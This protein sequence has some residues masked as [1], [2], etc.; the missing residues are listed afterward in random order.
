MLSY[1]D[2][3]KR[4]IEQRNRFAA[5]TSFKQII[6]STDE[7]QIIAFFIFFSGLG[8][9]MTKPVESWIKR[10]GQACVAKGFTQVGNLL[11]KHSVEEAS[12]HLMLIKD[13][14][15]LT[16]LWNQKCKL[17]VNKDAIL[18]DTDTQ[19]VNDYK[20]VHEDTIK[21]APWGQVAIEYEIENLS[22]VYGTRLVEKYQKTVNKTSSKGITFLKDHVK[23][24]VGHTEFNRNLI[25]TV[26]KE[27]PNSLETLVKSGTQALEAY[28]QFSNDC[29]E[30]A[31]RLLER[32]KS[33]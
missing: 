14:D 21:N 33:L 10:A 2:Y 32:E 13:L 12:H 4:M 22:L 8:V 30:K 15:V 28:C 19:G 16:T 24:D 20:T 1:Q 18:N 17:P 25:S 6:E 11:V 5:N 3:E 23:L 29:F 7:K 26:L 9:E 27:I 31:S